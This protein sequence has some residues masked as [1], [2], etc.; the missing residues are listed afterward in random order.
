M[1]GTHTKLPRKVP[2]TGKC[3]AEGYVGRNESELDSEVTK[4]SRVNASWKFHEWCL[5]RKGA[6]KK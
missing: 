5:V 6:E 4:E 1:Y 3:V 2:T